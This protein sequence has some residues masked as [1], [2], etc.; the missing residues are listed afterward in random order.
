MWWCCWDVKGHG[1]S[2]FLFLPLTLPLP[3]ASDGINGGMFL[4]VEV[5][6]SHQVDLSRVRLT[7]LRHHLSVVCV[8]LASLPMGHHPMHTLVPPP[9]LAIIINHAT[10]SLLTGLIEFPD[11]SIRNKAEYNEHPGTVDRKRT[12]KACISYSAPPKW[13]KM[14][15]LPVMV[16]VVVLGRSRQ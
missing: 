3:S 16:V 8:F 10:S 9:V 12:S 15:L 13:V 11:Q 6:S 7:P 4:F 14:G 1:R 2:F 5:V